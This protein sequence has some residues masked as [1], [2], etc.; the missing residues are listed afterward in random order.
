MR[1]ARL[2]AA[3]AFVSGVLAVGL[4]LLLIHEIDG[5]GLL[6]P[7]DIAVLAFAG[8]VYALSLAFYLDIDARLRE[9]ARAADAKCQAAERSQYHC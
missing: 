2:L 8:A 3:F 6:E 7:G 1:L 4:S 9:S 5:M